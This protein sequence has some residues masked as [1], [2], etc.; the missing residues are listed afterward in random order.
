M[1]VPI[2]WLNEYVKVDD[3]DIKTFEDSMIMSGSNTE[4]VEYVGKGIE[5]VVVGRIDKIWPHPNADKLV[6]LTADV[7]ERK[8]QI[9]TGATNINEGDYVPVALDGARLPGGV[10][11]NSGDLRGEL[12]DGMLCSA[13]ELGFETSMVPKD[14][15]DGIWILD[16]EYPLGEDILETLKLNDYI[17]E[18]EITPN[19]PDCLCMLGMA[20]EASATFKRPISYPNIAIKNPQ[21]DIEKYV[22][23]K[24]EDPDLCGRFSAKMVTDIKIEPSPLWMQL[25]LMKAGMRPINNIVDVTNYVMLERGQPLH[26]YDLDTLIGRTLIARRAKEGEKIKTLD[27]VERIMD[28]ENL[29]IADGEKSVGIAGIMGGEETE[30][31]SSTVNILIESA[32][33]TAKA[34][35]DTSRRIGHRTEASA[36]YEKGVD[37]DGTAK[38]AERACQLIEMLGAG[39]VIGGTIDVY[40]N[41]PEEISINVRPERINAILGSKLDKKFM[42]DVMNRLG[43]RCE[44]DGNNFIAYPPTNRLDLRIEADIVEEIARIFGY[45]NI[46]STLPKDNQWGG[47]TEK[48]KAEDKS[49]NI[50]TGMGLNEVLTYSFVSPKTHDLIDLPI[51]S[52]ERNVLKLINPL[53]EEYSI[54]RRTLVPNMMEVIKRN[55]NRKRE[56]LRAFELGNTFIPKEMPISQ[57]P[58]EKKSL[59]MAM[60]GNGNDFFALK[61][62]L[63]SYLK[64]MGLDDF[65]FIP[66]KELSMYHPGRTANLFV[67]GQCMGHIGE[68]HPNVM[69]NYGLDIRICMAEIDYEI[70]QDSFNLEK[71]YSP[72]PKYP[73]ITRDIAVKVGK[74]IYIRQIEKII[75]QNGGE[76]LTEAKLFDVY[77]GK[78]IEPGKKSVAYALIFQSTER[79]LKDDEVNLCFGDIVRALEIELKAE[80]RK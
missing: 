22:T 72:I 70:L 42:M 27:G 75:K 66:E 26:A 43:V 36:K 77:E 60:Y 25:R 53:G 5:K 18:F 31:T 63:A 37:I 71:F 33:F 13:Q 76:L 44:E 32:H 52:E 67:K 50:L 16:K 1:R 29:M 46:E 49:K 80:L 39:K 30:I 3:I 14:V 15:A 64:R 8:L 35:R 74:D 78:Q 7:G 47:K 59:V 24:V 12:S 56:T 34:L 20:K 68:I 17:I 23:I 19:R 51:G 2:E 65:E 69:E 55:Y 61:G 21:D 54:M 11:I 73:A 9:V 4:T 79:T 40:K 28:G 45:D 48:Q 57:L 41:K 6:V 38:A 10:V 58:A 62:V